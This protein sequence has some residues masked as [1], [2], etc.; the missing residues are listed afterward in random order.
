M[1]YRCRVSLLSKLVTQVNFSPLISKMAPYPLVLSCM[2]TSPGA[3]ILYSL[4]CPGLISIFSL[5]LGRVKISMWNLLP[6]EVWNI[7]DLYIE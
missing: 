6:Q 5:Y 3:G 7:L 2:V 4:R 1:A